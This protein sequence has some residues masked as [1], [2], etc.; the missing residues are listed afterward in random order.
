MRTILQYLIENCGYEVIAVVS[1]ADQIVSSCETH[2][3]NLLFIDALLKGMNAHELIKEVKVLDTNLKIVLVAEQNQFITEN[4]VREAGADWMVQKP[5][6]LD[7]VS[8]VLKLL[9]FG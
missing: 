2:R 9:L 3:P 7:E 1:S 4:E 5:F 8:K 6:V